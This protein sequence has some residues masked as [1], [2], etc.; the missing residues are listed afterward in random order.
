MWGGQQPASAA[1]PLPL[2]GS[3]IPQAA[4]EVLQNQIQALENK[5][6]EMQKLDAWKGSS[7]DTS[8]VIP[9]SQPQYD[10]G[11]MASAAL[12]NSQYLSYRP[13]PRSTAKIR[14]R[15]FGS[16]SPAVTSSMAS[17]ALSKIGTGGR[18]MMSPEGYAASSVKRLVIKPETMTPNT[19]MRLRLTNGP[20]TGDS[21]TQA[22][23]V[24]L[25]KTSP[26]GNDTKVDAPSPV[27]TPRAS[28]PVY[29]RETPKDSMIPNS[30]G[31]TMASLEKL[32]PPTDPAM[33]Y[34]K[35]V[36][37]SHDGTAPA[38][39]ALHEASSG[40][41]QPS[42]IPK[43]TKPGYVVS[44]SIER[45]ATMSEAELATLSGFSIEHKP[46]GKVEW[47]GEVDVRNADLDASIEIG[48]ADVGVYHTDEEAGCKPPPGSKLNRPCRITFYNIFPKTGPKA[49]AEAKEKYC[50]RIAKSTS[51]MDAK[52]ISYDPDT[53]VWQ[54]RVESF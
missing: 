17:A 25:D 48:Q 36:V 2:A 19:K 33:D 34:Y 14:P 42:Y 8:N 39:V 31:K 13:S 5:R 1:M 4:N 49:D 45:M 16:P 15:G 18:P 29:G 10:G 30:P 35:K 54:I 46:Y 3:I 47:D 53:G 22:L 32:A 50:K 52:L 23:P 37:E 43:L 44:P 24:P 6:K 9:A 7:P 51:K 38:P 12:N 40:R 21:V 41:K 28:I 11:N 20:V 26:T 27:Q